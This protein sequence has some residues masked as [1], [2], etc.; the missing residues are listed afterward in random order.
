MRKQKGNRE[1]FDGL[2]EIWG[3]ISSTNRVVSIQVGTS[4]K[5]HHVFIFNRVNPHALCQI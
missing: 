1:K 5:S 3:P 2:G 4:T